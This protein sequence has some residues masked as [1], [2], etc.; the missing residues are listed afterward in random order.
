MI[1]IEASVIDLATNQIKGKYI[2]SFDSRDNF[3]KW[4]NLVKNDCDTIINVMFYD[5][6]EKACLKSV[7]DATLLRVGRINPV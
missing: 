3:N 4:Y 7:R 6:A 5:S 2:K 1:N